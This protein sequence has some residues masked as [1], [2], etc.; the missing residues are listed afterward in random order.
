MIM[1]DRASFLTNFPASHSVI[2]I[3][4]SMDRQCRGAKS[5]RQQA[6]D[7]R[8]GFSH[9][10]AR[11]RTQGLRQTL[12]EMGVPDAFVRN[13]QATYRPSVTR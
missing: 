8:P 7:E 2:V 13:F 4:R 11:P 3:V 10:R 12:H 9:R 6:A 1:Y 5:R